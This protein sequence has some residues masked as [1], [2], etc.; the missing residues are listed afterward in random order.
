MKIQTKTESFIEAMANILVGYTVA[1]IS[2]ILIFPLFDIKVGI[3][4]NL[5]VG[6]WFTV[7]SLVR[8]YIIRR[9]FNGLKFKKKGN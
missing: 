1:I 7:V 9:F 5:W 3:K 8:S 4:T 2:Q 6:V